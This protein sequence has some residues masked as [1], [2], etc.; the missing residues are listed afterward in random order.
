MKLSA[1]G[2]SDIGRKRTNNE[3][4]FVIRDLDAAVT[5]EPPRFEGLDV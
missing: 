4:G 3:D 5:F 1:F 2:A